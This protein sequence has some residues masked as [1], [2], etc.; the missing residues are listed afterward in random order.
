[1]IQKQYSYFLSLIIFL[2]FI[3]ITNSLSQQT[4]WVMIAEKETGK[5][6]VDTTSIKVFD[7]Q[8]SIWSQEI[9]NSLEKFGPDDAEFSK[10]KTHYLFDLIEERF[11]VIGKLYY[12]PDGRIVGQS[13]NQRIT[14][15]TKMFM[16]PVKSHA[17]VELIFNK[18]VEFNKTKSV[19]SSGKITLKNELNIPIITQTEALDNSKKP[20]LTEGTGQKKLDAYSGK[21]VAF[22]FDPITNNT[23]ELEE[24]IK[25]VEDNEIL[26]RVEKINREAP[27]DSGEYDFT[28]ETMITNTIFSDGTLYCFQ[29]SSWK[30]RSIADN[31][32]RKLKRKGYNAF[33]VSAKPKHKRGTWHRVRIGYFDNLKETETFQ[34]KMK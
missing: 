34:K 8:L 15:A 1:M 4:H 3:L 29:V 17:E 5:I 26:N 19:T 7:E 10:I 30:T 14:G 12:N 16:L 25:K 2:L 31:E 18:A 6:Y 32:L 24:L 20:I 22:I 33:I 9:L 11:T 23:I 13:S 28:N 27:F 21:K